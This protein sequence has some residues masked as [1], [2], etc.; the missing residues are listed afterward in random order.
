VTKWEVRLF[1]NP[2]DPSDASFTLP[3]GWEPFAA[4]FWGGSRIWAKR[5]VK[6]ETKP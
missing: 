1:V 4:A 3:E 6:E 5:E 2:Y